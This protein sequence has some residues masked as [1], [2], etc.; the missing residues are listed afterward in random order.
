MKTAVLPL[1]LAF[2]KDSAAAPCTLCPSGIVNSDLIVPDSGGFSCKEASDLAERLDDTLPGC[3]SALESRVFCCPDDIVPVTNPCEICPSGVTNP[4]EIVPDSR[5]M[6]CSM[7]AAYGQTLDASSNKCL[8]SIPSRELCCPG[9]SFC[10]AGFSVDGST[11][12]PGFDNKTCDSELAYSKTEISP[13]ECTSVNANRNV[14]CPPTNPCSL[15][16]SG[17][18]NPDIVPP[19]ANG[20]TCSGLE[21]WLTNFEQDDSQCTLSLYNRGFCCPADIVPV[22]DPC[23]F[24]EDGLAVDDNTAVPDIA[25]L[26]CGILADVSKMTR[27]DEDLCLEFQGSRNICCP[28]TNPC[29]LCSTVENP[30]TIVVSLCAPITI[31]LLLPLLILCLLIP[32]CIFVVRHQRNNLFGT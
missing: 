25:G 22:A 5:Q 15:C 18:A 26:T 17:V 6:T 7:L 9:C 10:P 21:S 14:C 30:N 13:A 4:D 3:A 32:T 12:I 2:A 11:A 20:F 16:P 27:K 8:D 31:Y 1:L 29:Q 19:D 24:C 28:P 23:K